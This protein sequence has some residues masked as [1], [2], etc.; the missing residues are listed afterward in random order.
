MFYSLDLYNEIAFK[1]FDYKLSASI[2]EMILKLNALVDETSQSVVV[3]QPT[4][5]NRYKKPNQ[6]SSQVFGRKPR[7]GDKKE[8]DWETA[9]IPFKATTIV[10][11]EE[12]VEKILGDIR[13]S[14]N[15][16][17]NKNYDAQSRTIIESIKMIYQEDMSEEERAS[18]DDMV[19]Q[20]IFDTAINNKFYSELYTHLLREL[21]IDFPFFNKRLLGIVGQYKESISDIQFV[22]QNVDY[23]MHCQNNKRNDKRKSM[24]TFIVNLMKNDVID[25]TS[26]I[27][28]ILFL[29]NNIN[30]A[31]DDKEKAFLVDEITENIFIFVSMM[32]N[33]F[34]PSDIINRTKCGSSPTVTDNSIKAQT[35]C[36]NSNVHDDELWATIVENITLFSNMKVKEKVGFSS[37]AMFKYKD[38]LDL[39]SKA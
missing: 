7:G 26:V 29:Q 13:L 3:A 4:T 24:A 2:Q 11:K 6:Q 30:G 23:D 28:T 17:S 39:L 25:K 14:L 22:D 16:L 20:S 15:K 18:Y 27:E 19:T 32:K 37:R 38:L 31:L 1:G 33:D 36:A 8:S 21:L 35:E 12:G 5:N 34:T 10:K 9:R